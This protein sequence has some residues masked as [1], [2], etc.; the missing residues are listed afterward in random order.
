MYCYG[1]SEN[2]SGSGPA[3]PVRLTVLHPQTADALMRAVGELRATRRAKYLVVDCGDE[4]VDVGA[5]ELDASEPRDGIRE[6]HRAISGKFGS[7]CVLFVFFLGLIVRQSSLVFMFFISQLQNS[8][9]LE[10]FHA[11]LQAVHE[12]G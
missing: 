10:S 7:V 1:E 2:E 12:M 5:Y 6:L 3:F 8:S 4:T 9:H 11:L